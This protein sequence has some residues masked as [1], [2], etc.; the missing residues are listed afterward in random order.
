MFN[1][2]MKLYCVDKIV[3]LLY[4]TKFNY[5]CE[6]KGLEIGNKTFSRNYFSNKFSQFFMISFVLFSA[7]RASTQVLSI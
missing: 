5:T 2:I 7:Q 4:K 3:S 1:G 6:C